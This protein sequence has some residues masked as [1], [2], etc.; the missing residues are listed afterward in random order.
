MF[1][2]VWGKRTPFSLQIVSEVI[3]QINNIENEKEM[4]NSL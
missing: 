3:H 4:T 1:V 2:K